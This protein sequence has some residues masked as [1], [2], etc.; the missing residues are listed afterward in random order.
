MKIE[1]A[2]SVFIPGWA[3][4]LALQKV[5]INA[6]YQDTFRAQTNNV[7]TKAKGDIPKRMPLCR[8][9]SKQILCRAA[10]VF[11]GPSPQPEEIH[12]AHGCHAFTCM[13]FA[14]QRGAQLGKHRGGIV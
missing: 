11:G 7:H 9:S 12:L 1:K 13:A 2:D 10:L 8:A 3:T 4:D 5:T 14:W 6:S